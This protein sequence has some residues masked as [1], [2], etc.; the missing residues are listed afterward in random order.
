MFK[1]I[2]RY[3]FAKA[4]CKKYNLKLEL[5]CDTSESAT[6]WYKGSIEISLFSNHFYASLL[7]E[8]AHHMDFCMSKGYL[9]ESYC[10]RCVRR[11]TWKNLGKFGEERRDKYNNQLYREARANRYSLRMLKKLG[12]LKES[13]IS[14]AKYCIT[15]YISN[16]PTQEQ[17]NLQNK[18][19][20]ADIDYKLNRYLTY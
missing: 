17:N 12:I 7:H 1:Y 5:H 13:D 18:L 20:L 19:T 3:L 9:T 6:Y 10:N 8:L 14:W 16:L 2:K 11:V 4:I 15:S